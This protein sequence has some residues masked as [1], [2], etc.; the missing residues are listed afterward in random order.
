MFLEESDYH[1]MQECTHSFLKYGK[2]DLNNITF[3]QKRLNVY[4][5]RRK[6]GQ[7]IFCLRH[8]YLNVIFRIRI[9]KI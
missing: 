2:S 9:S 4:K 1:I 3:D 7:I 5:Q 6:L 8:L